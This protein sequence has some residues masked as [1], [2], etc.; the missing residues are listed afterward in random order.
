M[1]AASSS[2]H[3]SLSRFGRTGRHGQGNSNLASFLIKLN[4]HGFLSI[5]GVYALFVLVVV[6]PLFCTATLGPIVKLCIGELGSI[7]GIFE[8]LGAGVAE[9]R[10][11]VAEEDV[12]LARFALFLNFHARIIPQG[13]G[14]V[15]PKLR[16]GR[17][18]LEG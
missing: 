14:L 11:I 8:L 3:G 18:F 17:R 1:V 4:F 12:V 16:K 15:K 10:S 5:L 2:D 9:A 6:V 13:E 7:E